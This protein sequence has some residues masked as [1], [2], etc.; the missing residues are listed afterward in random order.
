MP[1]A[2]KYARNRVTIAKIE[3]KEKFMKDFRED[4][5]R[6]MPKAH[7]IK[8]TSSYFIDLQYLSFA[9]PNY[10]LYYPLSFTYRIVVNFNPF[11]QTISHKLLH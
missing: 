5:K 8:M 7:C 11:L 6:N 10:W 2:K 3:Q 4:A 1:N 9:S